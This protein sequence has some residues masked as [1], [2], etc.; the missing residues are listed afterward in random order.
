MSLAFPVTRRSAIKGVSHAVGG[1][2]SGVAALA[3]VDADRDETGQPLITRQ[4]G[5]I[6]PLLIFHPG[7]G[8]TTR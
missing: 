8:A 1:L 4:L 6:G 5:T 3:V 7:I 2:V